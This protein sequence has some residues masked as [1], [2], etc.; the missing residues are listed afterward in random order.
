MSYSEDK[1]EVAEKLW[2]ILH[3]GDLLFSDG[4][5]VPQRGLSGGEA[6]VHAICKAIVMPEEH[7]MPPL[8]DIATR[9]S[10]NIRAEVL[11][12]LTDLLGDNL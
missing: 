8:D 7:R 1:Y 3:K 2:S 10:A 9:L 11:G 12:A 6:I 4:R 5:L